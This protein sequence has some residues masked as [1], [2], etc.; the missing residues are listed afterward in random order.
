M[1]KHVVNFKFKEMPPA[2]EAA[3]KAAMLAMV[4]PI[5]EL[6]SLSFG[7]NISPRDT[8]YTHCLVEEF[9]DMEALGRYVVHPVH[10]ALLEEHIKPWVEHR[11]IVDYE[12]A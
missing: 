2:Q 3:L 6:R 1:I 9:D 4:G 8:T 12:M 10:E 5:P 11:T 7:R